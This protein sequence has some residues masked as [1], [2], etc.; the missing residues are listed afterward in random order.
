MGGNTLTSSRPAH[1][2][3]TRT[4]GVNVRCRIQIG[5]GPNARAQQLWVAICIQVG[6]IGPARESKLP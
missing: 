6:P 2:S 5:Y 1:A 4:R 3:S